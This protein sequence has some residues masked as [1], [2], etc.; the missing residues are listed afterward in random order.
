[1]SDRYYEMT[2]MRFK[3]TWVKLSTEGNGVSMGSISLFYLSALNLLHLLGYEY[4]SR[5]RKK[6]QISTRHLLGKP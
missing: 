2:P 5:S 6:K 4:E 3:L 1:M